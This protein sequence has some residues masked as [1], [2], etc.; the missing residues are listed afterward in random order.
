MTDSF[1]KLIKQ[2]QGALPDI[3]ETNYAMDASMLESVNKAQDAITQDFSQRTQNAIQLSQRLASYKKE[4]KPFQELAGLI[5][6]ATNAY[7]ELKKKQLAN[8]EV[9]AYSKKRDQIAWQKKNLTK[10]QLVKARVIAEGGDYSLDE[11][12]DIVLR[13]SAVNTAEEGEL[14]KS[15]EVVIDE[16]YKIEKDELNVAA[17]INRRE[18]ELLRQI[19]GTATLDQLQ[20]TLSTEAEQDI[21]SAGEASVVLVDNFPLWIN[22]V[23]SVPKQFPGMDRPLSYLDVTHAD[24]TAEDAAWAGALLKDAVADVMVANEDLINK[25]G[26]NFFNREIFPKIYEHI[27]YMHKRTTTKQ[28]ENAVKR[29]YN[30]SADSLAENINLFGIQAILSDVGVNEM[31]LDGSRNNMAGFAQVVN[32]IDHA[33]KRGT[34]HYEDLEGVLDDKFFARDGSET[35]LK[36][37]KPGIYQKLGELVEREARVERMNY[38]EDFKEEF[39]ATMKELDDAAKE[40]GL[41]RP[42]RETAL[43]AYKE[44]YSKWSWFKQGDDPIWDKWKEWIRERPLDSKTA[45]DLLDQAK[46][47]NS[48]YKQDWITS[49]DEGPIRDEYQREYDNG[50][51]YALT[52]D[53]LDSAKQSAKNQIL[54]YVR[55]ETWDQVLGTKENEAIENRVVDFFKKR[56]DHYMLNDDKVDTPRWREEAIKSA[57]SDL[58]KA[59]DTLGKE[60]IEDPE[61]FGQL[62]VRKYHPDTIQ[63]NTQYLQWIK[64]NP[65]EA[66]TTEYYIN[67]DEETAILEGLETGKIPGFFWDRSKYFKNM[68]PNELFRKRVEATEELR[69]KIEKEPT[70]K[71]K[72]YE[73]KPLLESKGDISAINDGKSDAARIAGHLIEPKNTETM[74][75]E[76]EKTDA[77]VDSIFRASENVEAQITDPVSNMTLRKI[78]GLRDRDF[79]NDEIGL[80]IYD[81]KMSTIFDLFEQPGFTDIVGPDDVFNKETQRKLIHASILRKANRY[82]ST[83]TYDNTYR[84]LKW[85]T[86]DEQKELKNIVSKTKGEGEFIDDPYLSINVLSDEVAKAFLED[87]MLSYA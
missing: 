68:N 49:L 21:R 57:K 28:L 73:I 48:V 81:L 74:L 6:T 34:L 63:N 55:A 13:E 11:A 60:G 70:Y 72:K 64:K 59:I 62:E 77:N 45:Q 29:N 41:A 67:T 61:L 2:Q 9:D 19:E 26:R 5:G 39:D 22:S 69:N 84:R 54:G 86:E 50:R 8:E 16:N 38:A 32:K 53:E 15:E 52:Q 66:K 83:K 79:W 75:N 56:F 42:D 24:A 33:L 14:W 17:A 23:L 58:E 65:A 51:G 4:G 27:Q 78:I 7:A 35:D 46:K 3:S 44:L 76:I 25:V 18:R 30:D 82:G 80:G 87:T 85:L 71:G 43:K 47:N 40:Q 1:S 20:L 12:V 36:T 10:Q 31:Q 37:L